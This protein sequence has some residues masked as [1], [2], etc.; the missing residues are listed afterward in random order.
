MCLHHLVNFSTL[1][2]NILIEV[3]V[4]PKF[5][6]SFKIL[7]FLL[8]PALQSLLFSVLHSFLFTY[9]Q[10]SWNS[11]PILKT[12]Q[13]RQ[14]RQLAFVFGFP[15]VTS[16]LGLQLCHSLYS[17]LAGRQG[18]CPASLFNLSI[19]HNHN[20]DTWVNAHQLILT[21]T[22]GKVSRLVFDNWS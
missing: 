21:C 12:V 6:L 13:N 18:L 9:G 3:S 15:A 5:T 1:R 8:L 11:C 19:R 7:F 2:W 22:M 4:I 16:L 17:S 10:P 14:S 20:T